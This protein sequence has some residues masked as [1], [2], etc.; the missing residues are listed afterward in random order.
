MR[1]V[2]RLHVGALHAVRRELFAGVGERAVD[3]LLSWPIVAFRPGDESGHAG[4]RARV[5][6]GV[7]PP[8][9][10]LPHPEVDRLPARERS[11]RVE[12]DLDHGQGPAVGVRGVVDRDGTTA[13][14]S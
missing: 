14:A 2:E 12:Q 5:A 11:K 9:P 3:L 8:S 10:A 13:Y 1:T 4:C 6:P 7:V